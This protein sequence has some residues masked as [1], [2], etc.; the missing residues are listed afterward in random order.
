M[1]NSRESQNTKQKANTIVGDIGFLFL[2]RV[3][4]HLN[5]A[6][7]PQSEEAIHS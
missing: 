5:S 2:T 7:R 3:P 6:I 4:P 1:E